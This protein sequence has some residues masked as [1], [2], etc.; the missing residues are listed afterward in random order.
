M[1][2]YLHDETLDTETSKY[3]MKLV[4]WHGTQWIYLCLHTDIWNTNSQNLLVVSLSIL[5]QAS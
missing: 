4:C 5:V 3:I 2:I 1:N